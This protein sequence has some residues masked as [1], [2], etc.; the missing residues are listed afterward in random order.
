MSDI[1]NLVGSHEKL[2]TGGINLIASENF[3][4]PKV[5]KALASDLAGRYHTEWYGG[6]GFAREIITQT[7]ELAKEAFRAK[8][9][10]VTPL[11][12]NVCD[13][14]VLFSLTEPGDAIAMVPEDA[15]GYPLGTDKFDRK[16]IRLPVDKDTYEF[17]LGALS[18]T[19][20]NDVKLTIL[21]SSFIPFP[22]PV[23][24]IR[25][26][27]DSSEHGSKLV[28]DGAHVLGLIAGGEFQDPLGEG[29]EILFG[30]THKSL[31]GPQG[32]IILT[33]SDEHAGKLRQYLD[34]DLESG[35]GL[36]DNPHVNRI[37]ALGLALEELIQ[38]VDYARRTIHNAKSLARALAG[39]GVPVRFPERDHTESHQVLL[40][41]EVP[42]AR[43]LCQELEKVSIFIDVAGRLG[44]AEITH[45]GLGTSEVEEI[46]RLIFEVYKNGPSEP[47]RARVRDLMSDERD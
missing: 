9:A 36:V 7:E 20:T 29:A 19:I 4:S 16:R 24:E 27:I 46:A 38:D 6:S 23:R 47:I 15:G 30:S 8:H 28:Y 35:I 31:Y 42:R 13:L 2:R 34:I 1:L 17:N 5:R 45:R 26:F 12:G 25:G 11:S 32:G 41:L 10:F 21:G 40:D 37:A 18:S 22:H 33:N 3:I 14:A 43:K 44:T 39:S